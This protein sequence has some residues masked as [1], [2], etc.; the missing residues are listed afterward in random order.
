ML[1]MPP[2]GTLFHAKAIIVYFTPLS[3][4]KQNFHACPKKI[5]NRRPNLAEALK[6]TGEG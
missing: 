3:E 6:N 2:G 5:K 1:L 4:V